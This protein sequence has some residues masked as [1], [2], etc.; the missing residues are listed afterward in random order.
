MNGRMVAMKKSKQS[1][2][3]KKA[4][5][6][7]NDALL[8]Q[9]YHEAGHA[10]M[11]F[12][13]GEAEDLHSVDIIP[14]T[15]NSRAGR[16][17]AMTFDRQREL[18][19]V[20]VGCDDYRRIEAI[21]WIMIDLAGYSA[22]NKV[23]FPD[24]PGRNWLEVERENQFWDPDPVSDFSKAEGVARAFCGEGRSHWGFI[25]RLGRWTDEAIRSPRMWKVVEVLTAELLGNDR[26][27]G[28][29]AWRIM[30]DAWGPGD[31]FP[32][33]STRTWK[34]R[35]RTPKIASSASATTGH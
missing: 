30:K 26:L 18:M 9:A 21:T 7:E 5:G 31:L 35:F 4:K 20:S 3:K 34:R 23:A 19:S 12:F 33:V 27:E 25:S 22:E 2:R 13:F 1:V 32:Y 15:Q 14:N 11:Y 29:T 17:S 28:K 10:A 24:C 16:T 8:P 6:G